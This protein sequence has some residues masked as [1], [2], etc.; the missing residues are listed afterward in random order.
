[1]ERL[2]ADPDTGSFP[3]VR[4]N[5]CKLLPTH[6][7]CL[8]V[9]TVGRFL[10]GSTGEAVC[11]TA[12]CGPCNACFGNENILRCRHHS[13]KFQGAAT[14]ALNNSVSRS[15]TNNKKKKTVTPA[16]NNNGNL[17]GSSQTAPAMNNK[18]NLDNNNNNSKGSSWTAEY[19][20]KEL[21]IL[22]QAHIRTSENSIDGASKQKGKF[23]DDVADSY[24]LLKKQQEKYDHH[25]W[26]Q[27]WYNNKSLQCGNMILSDVESDEESTL[28]EMELLPF[29]NSSSLQQKW[30]KAVQPN[31]TKFI[32]L[33]ERN[34]KR[35]GEGMMIINF[36]FFFVLFILT[37]NLFLQMLSG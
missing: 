28:D 15:R 17:K 10:F 21:L 29:H 13:T 18:V 14:P 19:S 31:V 33:T 20:A 6:H 24:Q 11:A 26:R 25:Q 36:V 8:A 9:V 37:I 12:V 7:R 16:T 35:S 23:W 30:S 22:S 2:E 27:R 32:G 1:M 4:C 5:S 3:V 34:P